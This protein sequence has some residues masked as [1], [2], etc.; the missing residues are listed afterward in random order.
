[1]LTTSRAAPQ[2]IIMQLQGLMLTQPQLAV[3]ELLCT[4]PGQLEATVEHHTA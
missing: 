1:M 3:V 4:C 2:A